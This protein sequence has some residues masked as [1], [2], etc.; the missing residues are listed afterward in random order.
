LPNNISQT[1]IIPDHKKLDAET[2]KA[3]YRQVS[4][5]V[6]ENEL[7]SYFHTP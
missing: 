6:P 7:Y 2:L 3:I 1:L 4:R 5:Y